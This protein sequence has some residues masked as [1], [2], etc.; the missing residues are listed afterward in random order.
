[1]LRRFSVVLTA[2]LALAATFTAGAQAELRQGSATDPVGDAGSWDLE[3]ATASYDQGGAWSVTMR[4]AAP[5]TPG[6]AP[7]ASV[8]ITNDSNADAPCSGNSSAFASLLGSVASDGD[9]VFFSTN[10]PGSGNYEGSRR[11]SADRREL[12][13]SKSDARLKDFDY[14]CVAIELRQSG[15]VVEQLDSPMFF[16]GFG[17]DSDADGVKD[18]V[19]DCPSEAGPAPTGCAPDTDADGVKDNADQCPGAAGTAPSGCPAPTSTPAPAPVQTTPSATTRKCTP[20]RLKGKSLKAAKRALKNAGCAVGKVTK[21]RKLR[22]GAKLVVKRQSGSGPV[23]LVL[24]V[25]KPKK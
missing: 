6:E 1:M 22:K 13:F 2:A 23:K 9:L 7:S 4:F 15:A 19:D 20:P 18:N 25:K 5:L 11:Y 17:P 12:T 8:R 10:A 21:P 24:G 3:S 14:R 16:D